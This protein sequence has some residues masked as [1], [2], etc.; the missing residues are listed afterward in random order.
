MRTKAQ[1][2][3]NDTTVTALANKRGEIVPF[4]PTFGG[5]G[6]KIRCETPR[7]EGGKPKKQQKRR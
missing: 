7:K 1:P 3:P 4:P 5:W 2:L 6:R